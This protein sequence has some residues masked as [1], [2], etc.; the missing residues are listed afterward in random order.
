MLD[1]SYS[2]VMSGSKMLNDDD[3]D[4]SNSEYINYT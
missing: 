3:D 4:I 1:I 2:C